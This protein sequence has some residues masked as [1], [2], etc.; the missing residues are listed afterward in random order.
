VSRRR[1]LGLLLVLLLAAASVS[2]NMARTFEVVDGAGVPLDPAYIVYSRIGS[3]LNPVHPVTYRASELVLERSDRTGRITIPS[4]VNVH[5]PFPIETHSSPW[6]ELVYVPRMHNAWGQFNAGSPSRRG[7]FEIDS[8]RRRGIV[9][10]LSGEPQLWQGTMS[11][12]SSVIQRLVWRPPEKAPLRQT[13]PASAALARELIEHF[14]QEYD[15]FLARYGDEARPRPDMPPYL[16]GS[17]DE[18]K[19]RWSESVETDL[20]REP[21]WGMLITRLFNDELKLFERYQGD[22]R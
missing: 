15:A 22:L 5:L 3:R 19:R 21:R 14:R 1:T 12:L 11:N 9:A 6:I 20:A 8:T 18:E 4:A 17:S 2:V 7:L 16:S 13:D 10:D